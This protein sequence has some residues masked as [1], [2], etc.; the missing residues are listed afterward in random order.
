LPPWGGQNKKGWGMLPWH[1]WRNKMKTLETTETTCRVELPPELD[2]ALSRL[3]DGPPWCPELLEELKKIRGRIIAQFTS[4]KLTHEQCLSRLEGSAKEPEFIVSQYLRGRQEW[5]TW[6]F[7][8]EKDEVREML[9]KLR[10]QC[11]A[12]EKSV[13]EAKQEFAEYWSWAFQR[14]AYDIVLDAIPLEFQK[15][16]DFNKLP[17]KSAFNRVMEYLDDV[18]E[19]GDELYPPGLVAFGGTGTGKTRAIF[20]MIKEA[21]KRSRGNP[22]DIRI[23]R[24]C[25][26]ADEI[27]SLSLHDPGELR[28]DMQEMAKTE[29]LFIDDLH[30]VKFTPR[31]AEELFKLIDNRYRDGMGVLVTCQVPGEALVKK[32]TGDNKRLEETARAI[33]RRIRDMCRA[34]DF[35]C[36]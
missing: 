27:R 25:D 5:S 35:D 4:G 22:S 32:L 17:N 13:V 9:I 23:K 14:Y 10:E 33:V 31:Y 15:P 36:K 16:I 7:P 1:G 29:W 21:V 12:G 2:S 24:A 20:H 19:G 11:L 34:V 28:E 18:I 26:L 6:I 8:G 3:P 30:Q